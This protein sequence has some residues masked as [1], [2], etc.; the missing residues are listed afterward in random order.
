MKVREQA[1]NFVVGISIFLANNKVVYPV[2]PKYVTFLSF[3]LI[4]EDVTT[5]PQGGLVLCL[6]AT[7][8]FRW[9]VEREWI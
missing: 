9:I 5:Q 6:S 2:P 3:S 8:T 7:S 4:R 1:I